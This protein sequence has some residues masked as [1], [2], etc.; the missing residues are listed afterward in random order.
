MKRLV[1]LYPD[2]YQDDALVH[3]GNAGGPLRLEL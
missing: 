3:D 1:D 2:G